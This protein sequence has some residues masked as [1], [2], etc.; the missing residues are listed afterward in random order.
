[1][2]RLAAIRFNNSAKSYYFSTTLDLIKG[3]KVVVETIRGLELGE[4]IADLKD[5][6]T[7]L[8][9]PHG[10]ELSEHVDFLFLAPDPAQGARFRVFNGF[11][12]QGQRIGVQLVLVHGQAPFS[13]AAYNSAAVKVK[14]SSG[15]ARSGL[16][17]APVS[18]PYRSMMSEGSRYLFSR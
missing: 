13:R 9:K 15:V 1:M 2:D 11:L 10:P 6:V 12:V 7:Y 4:V 3:D 16:P 8:N 5:I 18:W 14:C 17:A